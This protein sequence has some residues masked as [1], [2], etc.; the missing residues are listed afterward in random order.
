MASYG[1]YRSTEVNVIFGV[2]PLKDMRADS[3][4]NVRYD[5]MS[6]DTIKGSDG[7]MTR[8]CTENTKVYVDYIVKRSSNDN[9]KLSALHNADRIAPGGAGVAKFLMKDNQGATL[10][11]SEKAFIQGMPDSASAKDVGGD[12]T[13][14][15]VLQVL[16]GQHII[17][18]NQIA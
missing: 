11:S 7:S 16:P 15:F 17:G 6:F 5:E 4:V 2:L 18:G 12:V 13:W 14:T 8:Y 10:L 1:L 3:F 9:Q